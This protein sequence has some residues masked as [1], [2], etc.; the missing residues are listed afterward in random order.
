MTSSTQ[1]TPETPTRAVLTIPNAISVARLASVP[2]FVWLFVSGREEAAVIVF[3]IGAATDFLDGFLARRLRSVSEFGKLLDPLADR[4][5]IIAL[6]I[7]LVARRAL[8]GWLALVVV[9]RDVLLLSLWPLL[10]RMRSA[11]IPVTF[12]G[13]AGTAALLFGLTWLALSETSFALAAVGRPVG[14]ASVGVGAVLYWA[15][16]AGYA[17]AARARA[18]AE[19]VG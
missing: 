19:K 17:R 7:A 10:E 16:A 15:A 4:I 12:I 11:R 13:K 6:S 14:L 8:P 1:G 3:G 2:L 5:L 18:R 9:A